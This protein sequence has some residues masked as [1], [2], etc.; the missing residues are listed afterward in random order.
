MWTG[1]PRVTSQALVWKVSGGQ[2]S[3]L[4]PGARPNSTRPSQVRE[5][6]LS[7]DLLDVKYP[8]WVSVWA[9]PDN[10]SLVISS[11]NSPGLPITAAHP[12][13][14]ALTKPVPARAHKGACIICD[15]HHNLPRIF[16]RGASHGGSPNSKSC[17]G[18]SENMSLA[19][20]T[21]FVET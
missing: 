4:D 6:R 13:S 10:L 16:D 2:T 21:A 3:N 12:S 15:H 5:L 14:L 17:T 19:R 7:R 9:R 11:V 1:E 8:V 20:P 18:A